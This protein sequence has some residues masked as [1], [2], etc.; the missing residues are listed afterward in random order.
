M[1]T[2]TEKQNNMGLC[3]QVLLEASPCCLGWPPWTASSDALCRPWPLT[4][5][6][7]KQGKERKRKEG[8]T[9]SLLRGLCVLA[10]GWRCHCRCRLEAPLPLLHVLLRVEQD[11]VGFGYI[12]HA[13]GHRRTQAQ[14]HSQCG[15]LDVDLSHGGRD[16]MELWPILSHLHPHIALGMST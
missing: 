6:T 16:Q 5:S 9:I 1:L 11:D 13:E 3:V 4:A 7:V 10:F 12:E 14:G 2:G 15:G 8:T